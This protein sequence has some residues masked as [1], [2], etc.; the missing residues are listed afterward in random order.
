MRDI[1]LERLTMLADRLRHWHNTGAQ[2]MPRDERIELAMMMAATLNDFTEFVVLGMKFL[3]FNTTSMQKDIALF[4]ANGPERAMV[5]AQRGEAKTTLAALLAVWKLIQDNSTRVMIISA[6]GKQSSDVA[7]LIIRLIE[8]WPLLAYLRAD[9]QRGDRTSYE[10][11]DVHCDLKRTDK[12]A[13][14]SCRSMTGQ[15]TGARADLL[16]ADDVETPENGNN[17]AMR[18]ALLQKT[19]EFSAIASDPGARILYLGTPQ[20][21][22]SVYKTLPARGFTVRV[23]PGRYPTKEQMENYGNTLAPSISS[24]IEADETLG[25]PRFGISGTL[26][27]PTDPERYTEDQLCEKELDYGPEGFALQYML[28]TTLSDEA[29]TRIKLSDL[30]FFHGNHEIVPENVWYSADTKNAVPRDIHGP[31]GTARTYRPMGT[32]DTLR[33]F[34]LKVMRIDPAGN[35]GD[36]LAFAC[37]GAV[38]GYIHLLS[39]GGLPGGISKENMHFVLKHAQD[40]GIQQIT[41]ESNMGHGTVTQLLRAEMLALNIKGITLLDDY[42]KGQKERRILDTIGPVARRHRLVVHESAVEMDA[43]TL[44]SRPGDKRNLYSAWFQLANLTYDRGCLAKDDRADAIEG[45]VRDLL[46]FIGQDEEQAERNRK[47]Q[48]AEEFR[49]NPMGYKDSDYIQRE[50]QSRMQRSFLSRRR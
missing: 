29:K 17:H 49:K 43:E 13:S 9:Q 23:W 1:T 41:V 5:A 8:T 50:R 25:L 45:V 47:A 32:A 22:H 30:I 12:S 2:K 33:P 36:E 46:S 11:Y 31:F 3:G 39:V 7:V 48:A 14:I 35:G 42:A 37:G 40:L 19:K 28:D 24:A 16:I 26:G 10:A 38:A 44:R 20:T 34:Q 4:M 18:E 6:A 27:A 21:K 15:I